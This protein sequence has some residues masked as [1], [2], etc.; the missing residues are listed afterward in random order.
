MSS[1]VFPVQLKRM[2]DSSVSQKL[3]DVRFIEDRT[4]AEHPI[5]GA[6]WRNPGEVKS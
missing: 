3:V 1:L 6:V 5:P 4:P 2:Q